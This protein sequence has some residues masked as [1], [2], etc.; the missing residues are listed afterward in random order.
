VHSGTEIEL[1]I[2]AARAYTTSARRFWWFRKSSQ[3][4]P[5]AKEKVES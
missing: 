5:D 4:D 2:P 3:K 1:T